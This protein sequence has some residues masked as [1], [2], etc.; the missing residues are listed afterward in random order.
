LIPASPSLIRVLL[1]VIWIP[2]A[3]VSLF[4]RDKP[5]APADAEAGPPDAP[6]TPAA[7]DEEAPAPA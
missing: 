7:S 2:S 5:T 6:P 3:I 1:E 4:L